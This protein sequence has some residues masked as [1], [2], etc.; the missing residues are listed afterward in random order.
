MVTE[1]IVGAIA[2][3]VIGYILAQSNLA[4]RMRSTLRRD[5]VKRAL[6]TALSETFSMVS[7]DDPLLEPSLF[8]ESFLQ[9][10]AV[11]VLG[12]VLWRHGRPSGQELAEAWV[13][14]V[15]LKGEKRETQLDSITPAAEQFLRIYEQEAKKQP[16]LQEIFD[17][18]ARE[19]TA[20]NTGEI[21]DILRERLLSIPQKPTRKPLRTKIPDPRSD[22]LVGR[23]EEL[24][25]VRKRLQGRDVAAVA[26]FRG[27]GGIG[28]TELAIAAVGKLDDH[29][30]KRV[31]WID[32]GPNEAYAIQERIAAALGIT[33]ESEDLQIRADHISLTLTQKP[34]TLVILDDLRRRHIADYHNIAP[35]CPPCSLLITSRRRDLPISS[36]AVYNL[37]V[38]SPSKSRELLDSLLPEDWLDNEP[39]AVKDITKLLEHIPLALTLAARRA[40]RIARRQDKSACTPM[41]SLQKELNKRRLQVLNQGE[42][43][44]RPDLSVVITF[45]ASYDDLDEVDQARLS[46]LG[47]FARN[48][49]ELPALMALW[50]DNERSARLALDRLVDAGL[51]EEIEQ[52]TWWMHD[53]FREYAA[54]QLE[55]MEG[56]NIHEARLVHATYWQNYLE[57]LELLTDDDW[58]VLETRRP[59]IVQAADWLF[60][61]WKAQPELAANLAVEIGET[62]PYYAFEQWEAWVKE[63]QIAAEQSN[64]KNQV[65][66]LQKVLGIKMWQQGEVTA[67]EELFQR[68]LTTAREL[69]DEAI[70]DEEL[71]VAERGVSVTS[72][73]IADILYARG[74]LDEALRIRQEEELPVYEKLGDV[75]SRA[76]T[77]GQIADILYAR[78]ELDEALRIRQEEELPVYEKLGDVRERAVTMGKIADILYARG[79]LD[80]AL[81]IRQEE[82]LPVYEKLGDVREK[83]I[84]LFKLGD[85]YLAQGQLE[86]ASEYYINGLRNFEELLGTEHFYI[87]VL[88]NKLGNVLHEIGDLQDAWAY[89]VRSLGILRE[90]LPEDHPNIKKVEEDLRVIEEEYLNKN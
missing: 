90:N 55:K 48:Q 73:Q 65:R 70:T 12:Q 66:R 23:E 75:R 57:E 41:V 20:E 39:N 46:R 68:S 5:P 16:E 59:E 78:G 84:T 60:A 35:P 58:Q 3:A 76:V 62:F 64:Q 13:D 10:E 30:E 19:R 40:K 52:D 45:H 79:E 1:A 63:G 88:T 43:P 81:R 56:D 72:G 33:L 50:S 15:G 32:C 47:V 71:E 74:E 8:D 69:Y 29:F 24:N 83:G 14:S 82:E 85:V 6:A 36:S 31:V 38:L 22:R 51:L 80:E 89:K 11:P 34:P 67:A 4:D 61:N 44:N 42:D 28:K 7:E 25:W 27:I 18:K 54:E 49:F 21:R 77:M 17:Q 87:A 37:N 86:L 26:S 9:H 2:E 53:L